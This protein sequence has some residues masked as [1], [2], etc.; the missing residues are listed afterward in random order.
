M[1]LTNNGLAFYGVE[2]PKDVETLF[3]CVLFSV[4]V[5]AR[6]VFV[7]VLIVSSIPCRSPSRTSRSSG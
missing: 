4:I 2:A 7:R 1:K 6:V 3:R 5:R